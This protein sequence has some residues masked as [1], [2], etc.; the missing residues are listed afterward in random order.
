ML[1][2]CITGLLV[3]HGSSSSEMFVLPD[4]VTLITVVGHNG[5]ISDNILNP[6]SNI[7]KIID[8][9]INGNAH[10]IQYMLPYRIIINYGGCKVNNTMLYLKDRH[11]DGLVEIDNRI[12]IITK[13]TS[14]LVPYRNMCF[15][16]IINEDSV[17]IDRL[18][19]NHDK[20]ILPI[21]F[22]TRA[23]NTDGNG[24]DLKEIVT[25]LS[26]NG[27]GTFVTVICNMT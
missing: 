22:M 11:S 16:E 19:V 1:P 27:G 10:T 24:T 7:L 5:K 12:G 9:I 2:P 25:M 17:D 15:R 8:T 3:F 18:F 20:N 21:E 23:Y 14:Q 4:N 6:G 13:H 26:R